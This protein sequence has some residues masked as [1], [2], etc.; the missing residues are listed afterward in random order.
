MCLSR[1]ARALLLF[2]MFLMKCEDSFM[3]MPLI[4]LKRYSLSVR[5]FSIVWTCRLISGHF[6]MACWRCFALVLWNLVF[7]AKTTSIF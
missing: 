1:I 7:F 6:S 5:G 2:P 4:F 3:P